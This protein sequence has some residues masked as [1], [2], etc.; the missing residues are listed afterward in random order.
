MSPQLSSMPRPAAAALVF[1]AALLL[2][3]CTMNKTQERA[4][5]G[6]AI[7]AGVGTAIGAMS[8]GLDMGAGAVIGGIVGAAGGLAY[9]AIEGDGKKPAQ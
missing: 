4:V 1:A 7:G 2:S 9:D 5:T 6:A 3:A 8:G